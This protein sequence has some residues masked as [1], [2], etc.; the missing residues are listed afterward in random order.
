MSKSRFKALL[1]VFFFLTEKVWFKVNLCHRHKHSTRSFT[2]KCSNV[3]APGF[4]ESEKKFATIGSC[5][6]TTRQATPR[7]L[8]PSWWQN[9][10]SQRRPSRRTAPIWHHR[11]S[12]CSQESKEP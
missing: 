11:T 12:F 4:D 6:M 3:C 9:W 7:S 10:V 5:I 8:S 2:V 1:I